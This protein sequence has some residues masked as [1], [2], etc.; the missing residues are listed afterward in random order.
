VTPLRIAAVLAGILASWLLSSAAEAGDPLRVH[1]TLE[2]EHFIVHYWDPLEPVARRIAVVGEAAHRTL[3]PA[4]DHQPDGKT[5]IVV[6]DDTDSANGFAGVLPRN[7]I[8]IFATAPSSF[9]ELDDHDDWLF[10][11]TAHEYTHVLHLDTMS[12]LPNIYNGIFGKTW[13]PN[14]VMPRWVIEGIA[15]YE[16]SKHS[17]GGRN[18][19]SRFDQVIRIARHANKDLRLDQVSGSPRIFPRGNAAYIYGSHFLRYIFDRFGDDTLR[20]M[21]H[22]SGDYAPP[23][24]IN[25]QI[26]KVVGQPFTELYDDWKGYLRDRYGMQELAAERRGLQTGRQLTTSAESNYY[27]HYTSDSKELVWLQSDGYS[28]PNVRAIPVGADQSRSRKVVQMDAMGPFDVA[29]DGSLIYEQSRLYRRD[30]SFQD[31]F[32]WDARTGQTVR[33]THGKRAR[34]PSLSLDQRQIAY[35]RN[36][37]EGAVLVVADAVPNAPEKVVWK[38]ERYDRAYQPAWSPDGTRIAFS[39]WRKNGYRDILLLELATGTVEEITRDRAVDMA[40]RWAPDGKTLY[41]DSDRTGISN[42]YAWDLE[43]RRLWQVT[44]VLGGAFQ[45][46]PSPDGKL[47]AFQAAAPKGGYDLFELPVD[48][49][50]WLPA[51]AMIDDR[52]EPSNVLDNSAKVSEAR[53]YRA[54]ESLAPQAWTAALQ[55]GDVP[56]LSLQTSGSDAFGLHSY[57]LALGLRLDNGEAN[58]GASYSYTRMRFPVRFAMARTLVERGGLRIDGMNRSFREED[59][60]ATLSSSIPFESRPH[61][62][63]SLSFDYDIDWFRKVD[64]DDIPLDPSMRA[65]VIPVTDYVQSGVGMR[66]GF[67]TTRGTTYGVGLQSGFD[68]SVGIR[69][70]HPALGATYRN[71]TVSYNS[72]AFRRLWG[73]TPVLAA[74]LAGS[75]RSGDT[76]RTG[77]FSLGG[78]PAQDIAQAVVNSTRA[79]VMGYLRG[80]PT[81]SIVGNQFHLLNLEYRQELFAIERGIATLPVYARRMHFAL[82]SDTGT[83]FDTRFDFDRN[84]RQ[85]VGAALRLDLFF[86]YFVPGTL[87]LGYSHGVTDGGVGQSWMLLTGTL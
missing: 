21:S 12:G 63:W 23:F 33:L 78:V 37:P 24:A 30:Y 67:S 66:L 55:T 58:I 7:A 5:I 10:G 77:A 32:R 69:L 81:R 65:P 51:R 52:P 29:D 39:A 48:R 50:T 26:A 44:N 72:N 38:G 80:F 35:S 46:A 22:A 86:G 79:G 19:G 74:R 16:E 68:G 61:A 87:E 60:S 76:L 70:D 41:F 14:Q 62:S 36:G 82:L 20:K 56:S 8:Q 49:S 25:R 3:S 31:L 75:L 73:K 83:A 47:L 34:D 17:A 57:S 18:R 45:A 71:F 42:L 64:K 13:A 15:V 6:V 85:S 27:P 40:P 28:N 9:T 54:T 4:L 53:P 1:R 84:F 2:T 11:L 59:W 43:E